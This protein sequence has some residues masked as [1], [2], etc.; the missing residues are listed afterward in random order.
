METDQKSFKKHDK[1]YHALDFDTAKQKMLK[2]D[3]LDF[4]NFFGFQKALEKNPRVRSLHIDIGSGAGWLIKHTAPF[5]KKVLAIEPSVAATDISKRYNIQY[6]NIEYLNV[7]MVEA[8]E[9][10]SFT[11]PY[12]LTTA[13]VF[14]HIENFHV[15]N[16]LK[17]LNKAPLGSVILFCEPYDTN[18]QQPFWYIRN[19]AW[20]QERLPNWQLEFLGI[21]GVW[22]G[23]KEK[24][25]KGIYGVCTGKNTQSIPQSRFVSLV[26]L[27]QGWYYKVRYFCVKI[28]KN[29]LNIPEKLF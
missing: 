7:D 17:L 6:K 18:I 28:I 23:K 19:K 4:F 11:E 29:I 24:Y 27:L 12:F 15:E 1:V 25:T 26:W 5:F 20:W 3:E 22:D 9:N 21:R 14:C 16:F 8:L 13:A 2:L 10:N